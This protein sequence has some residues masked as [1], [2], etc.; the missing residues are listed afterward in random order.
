MQRDGCQRPI[1]SR[2]RQNNL[3]IFIASPC[4]LHRNTL[5]SDFFFHLCYSRPVLYT[6]SAASP[7]VSTEPFLALAQDTETLL[8][9]SD[10]VNRGGV[11]TERKKKKQSRK[12]CL[13]ASPPAKALSIY[14]IYYYI[15]YVCVCASEIYIY[16]YLYT[17]IYY[18]SSYNI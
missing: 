16:I 18:I 1:Q 11:K 12:K 8:I 7:P 3:Y 5:N 6:V 2:G 10:R 17:Y 14:I 9:N 13:T 4:R 15:L